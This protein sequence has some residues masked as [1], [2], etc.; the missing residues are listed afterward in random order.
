MTLNRSFLAPL[1]L[2]CLVGCGGKLAH[3]PVGLAKQVEALTQENKTL[4]AGY[5]PSVA[6]AKIEAE[7]AGELKIARRVSLVGVALG[8]LAALALRALIPGMAWLGG[9]VAVACLGIYVLG[10]LFAFFL[11]YAVW[12][13]LAVLVCGGVWGIY[14]L[15]K[16]EK[17]P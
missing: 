11:P 6:A 3:V 5:S 7:I 10:I 4:K 9:A 14:H 13:T 2:L 15:Y 12:T 8:I 1:V 16:W 17:T